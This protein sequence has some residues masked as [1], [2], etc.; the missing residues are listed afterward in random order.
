VDDWNEAR[1]DRLEEQ[2]VLAR[3]H[4]ELETSVDPEGMTRQY[5]IQFSR[6]LRDLRPVIGGQ[7]ESPPRPDSL[8]NR[9]LGYRS[10][11]KRSLFCLSTQTRQI[12]PRTRRM[13]S[14]NRGLARNS[15]Q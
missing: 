12:P 15:S 1:L 3:L 14:I 10:L 2:K 8:F 11:P 9:I 13:S 4:N 6:T 7:V 5:A